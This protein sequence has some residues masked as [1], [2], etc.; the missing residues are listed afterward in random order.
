MRCTLLW[1]KWS[2]ILCNVRC[3][4]WA[5]RAK[6]NFLAVHA[7]TALILSS[8]AYLFFVCA[9]SC[10]FETIPR[11]SVILFLQNLSYT[12]L[13]ILS[14]EGIAFRR[15]VTAT[16]W[17]P[18]G[19]AECKLDAW[20]L[21]SLLNQ[22]QRSQRLCCLWLFGLGGLL[23]PICLCSAKEIYWELRFLI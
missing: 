19:R 6:I 13:K 20:S 3:H 16:A 17:A 8:G 14:Q 15:C 21:K 23:G 18:V 4:I 10:Q 9:N 11:N 12:Q 1:I 5:F 22:A 7:Q 2:H